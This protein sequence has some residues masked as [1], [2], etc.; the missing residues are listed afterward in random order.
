MPRM[1]LGGKDALRIF[2]V[3]GDDLS[4]ALLELGAEQPRLRAS[5]EKAVPM[6]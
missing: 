3:G 4:R 6:S 5:L 2:L 1:K